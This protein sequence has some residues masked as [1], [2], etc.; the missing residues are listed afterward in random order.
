[1]KLIFFLIF[2]IDI[3][4]M[5]LIKMPKISSGVDCNTHVLQGKY[6]DLNLNILNIKVLLSKLIKERDYRY[7][8]QAKLLSPRV[9]HSLYLDLREEY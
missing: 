8:C 7:F 5:L 4:R 3:I 2:P 6:L 9:P 1:M